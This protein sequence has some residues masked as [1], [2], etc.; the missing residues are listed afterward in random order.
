MNSFIIN[1][2]AVL[3]L[4]FL[5]SEIWCNG[6]EEIAAA[7]MEKTEQEALYSAIEGFVGTWWNGSDLYPDPCGW[8]P[9]QGV[10][11]DLF[12]DFW[13]VTALSIG[14]IQDNSLDCTTDAEFRPQ[15]FELKHLKTLSFFGCF[16]SPRHYPTPIPTENWDKLAGSLESLEFRSNP[17]LTGQIPPSF[18]HLRHLQSLVL[19][20]NGLAGELLV[21]IGSLMG[22]RR[23]V[24]ARNWLT[25]RIPDSF[26]GLSQL[27][28]LDLSRNFLSGALPLTLGGL[29]SLL[30]LDLSNNK[31]EGKLPKELGNLKNLTLLDLGNN[32]FSGGLVESLQD[33]SSLEEMVLSSNFIG[34]DLM[35]VEW[36]SLQSLAI[37]DLSNMGLTGEIPETIADLKR[38]RFLGLNDNNLTGNVPPKLAA[39]PCISA[40]YLNGNNLT[41]ELKFPARFYG[42]MGRRFGAWN[43]SNLCYQVELIS[44]NNAS[45]GVK[46]CQPEVTHFDLDSNSKLG[47]EYLK[48]QSSQLMVS[49]GFS[50]WGTDAL[51][52]VFL[53]EILT[54]ILSLSVHQ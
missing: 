44:L 34:G 7:P 10:S 31:L 30:K 39:L 14:P 53:A 17:G 13:Y 19:L 43:N 15:L 3:V 25:G 50:R 29:T 22:L 21:N 12:D 52:W 9:I 41:G 6:T 48:N 36:K 42:R 27:L 20:E 24:L 11:C 2:C 4:F 46:P 54:V 18:A 33:M 5:R 16:N 37:L 26:G 47:S 35:S 38:L 23:L 28:I 1:S 40:L 32:K 8:T 45:F 51:C 49:L